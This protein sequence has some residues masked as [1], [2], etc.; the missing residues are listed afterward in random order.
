MIHSV[1]LQ[2][3]DNPLR[4]LCDLKSNGESSRLAL[5][6]AIDLRV[7]FYVAKAAVAI[8][9]AQNLL[10]LS[11]ECLTVAAMPESKRCRSCEHPLTN[12]VGVEIF[13]AGDRDVGKLVALPPGNHVFNCLD[14]LLHRL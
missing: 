1:D 13:I 7:N 8:K 5:I 9:I 11:Q 6:F 2:M 12:R 10:V 14:I 3:I 4:A